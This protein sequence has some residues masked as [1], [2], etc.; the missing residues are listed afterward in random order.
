M[1]MTQQTESRGVP[2][3]ELLRHHGR[4]PHLAGRE[5]VPRERVLAPR[6]E[7]LEE[8][9][10]LV[11]APAG[12]G[13]TTFLAQWEDADERPFAWITLDERYNDPVLLLGSIAAAI[14]EITPL[15]DAV[16]APLLSPRPNLWDVVV[17]R[18]CHALRQCEQPFVIVLDDVHNLNNP[19]ALR[20]LPELASCLNAGSTLAITSRDEPEMPLGRLR[21]QRRL[22]EV[23]A[24]ELMMTVPEAADLL[25]EA[26][27]ELDHATVERL[28]ERT[29]G[30]PAGL[31]LAALALS[32][33]DDVER[34][35]A[36][37]YGDDRFVADYV[38]D[39]FLDGLSAPDLDF[40]TRTSLLDRLFGPLCD[41][42][43]ESGGST[44][45]L[46]RMARSNMLLVPL[47]RRDREYRYHALLQ[48]MLRSELRRRD[49][50][51]EAELHRR[52]SD[53]YAEHDD[54]EGAVKHAIEAGD[55][56]RAGDLIW[57]NTAA[58]ASG[59]RD[60]TLRLWLSQFSEREI[61]ESPSLCLT[62]ATTSLSAGDGAQVEHWTAAALEGLKD[63]PPG[64]DEMLA[65]AAR[66]IRATGAARDGVAQMGA[67]VAGI[68][69]LLPGD[70]PWRSVCR[71]IEGTSQQLVG[72]L[73]RAQTL[74]E[75]GSR[76]G[77]ASAPH[78]QTL[79]LAQLALIALDNDDQARADA[80]AEEAIA[81][82]RHFG[83]TEYPS[84][85]LV[86]AVAALSRARTAN[87]ADATRDLR[88]ATELTSE[89]NDLS[90]WYEAEVRV[91]A[92]RALLLLDDVPAARAHL[93]QAA[94]YLHRTPDATVIRGWI[95]RAWAEIDTARSVVGRW[96][97][98]PA[99]LRLLH[100]LPTHLT[101]REIADDL[102]VSANTVKTQAR[103][104]Y[105]KLGVSSRA[106]AV[107][108]ARGAGLLDE[109]GP[110]PS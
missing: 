87:T 42:V 95:E 94:R 82:V 88:K 21:T 3:R 89:L 26:G 36:D 9:M 109:P 103:S 60:A 85:S 71:L 6:L 91:V 52:A 99:E 7:R 77:E 97:L 73:E 104:I 56:R 78:I 13:K 15:D 33:E 41:A 76:R 30:W 46:R 51:A 68:Y 31:Y 5:L 25:E 4:R 69:E 35:V 27:L 100:F 53:W 65:L 93:A 2:T 92:A 18:L 55:R 29:E 38:R 64:G 20:P 8:S 63:A 106:E 80:L 48:E 45:M 37:F 11:A 16:F 1:T 72:E 24:R 17:P 67:D 49:P 108:C 43:L 19:E 62:A 96:P 14:D 22:G 79:C 61:T 10:V 66:V 107:A 86:F 28:V 105:R 81:Q 83:L 44:E 57:A 59:G 101:F 102:F 47:D 39:A 70:S 90:P 32:A 40:L 54:L 58:Y 34:A 23:R 110:S 84:S 50:E 12:Y 74:L 75:E 98:S